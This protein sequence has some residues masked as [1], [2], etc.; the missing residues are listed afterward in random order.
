MPVSVLVAQLRDGA[1][2]LEDAQRHPATIGL[3]PLAPERP[4]HAVAMAV[5]RQPIER[6]APQ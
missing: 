3:N 1:V 6:A 2:P 5:T 4:M